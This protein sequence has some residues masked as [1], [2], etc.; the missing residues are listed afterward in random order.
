MR[1]LRLLY[2]LPLRI[3]SLLRRDQVEQE[4]DD[5]LRDH[6]QR[7]IET[8]IARGLMADDARYTPPCVRW[9]VSSSE[10]RSVAT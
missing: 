3:R 8:D 6:L 10:R 2:T 1:L 5:E 9:A 7:R 4:L